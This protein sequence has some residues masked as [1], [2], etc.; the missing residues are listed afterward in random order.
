[1]SDSLHSLYFACGV[2]GKAIVHRNSKGHFNIASL[3]VCKHPKILQVQKMRFFVI[4]IACFLG[5][6]QMP[7]AIF[8][9]GMQPMLSKVHMM[10]QCSVVIYWMD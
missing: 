4:L 9:C 7:H 5:E 3:V 2:K 6:N 10:R 8:A 1:M